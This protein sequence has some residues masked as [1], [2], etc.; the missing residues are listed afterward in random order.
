MDAFDQDPRLHLLA[1]EWFKGR[2]LLDVGC[3]E[4]LVTL[5]AA[6][7]WATASVTGVDIDPVLIGKASRCG[8]RLALHSFTAA[9]ACLLT[10]VFL[11][12]ETE[13]HHIQ[14]SQM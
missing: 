4:G 3:N 10:C 12:H 11:V 14:D 8:A 5:A 2:H 6:V 7:R 9:F 1:P 13:Q